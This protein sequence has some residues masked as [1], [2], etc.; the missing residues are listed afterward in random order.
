MI[1]IVDDNSLDETLEKRPSIVEYD[2]ERSDLFEKLSD[3]L[4][5]SI[6][7][8][9]V[10]LR[11]EAGLVACK[12]A[13]EGVHG[14][15]LYADYHGQDYSE[16]PRHISESLKETHQ[17]LVKEGLRDQVTIIASGGITLA[18]HV[19]K[20]IICGADLVGIDTTVLVALQAEFLGETRKRGTYQ[21]RPRKIDLAWG[22]QRLVNL[23]G[24][25]HDQLIEILSA[26]GMR[27]VR[28]LRGDIGRSMMDAELREQSFKGIAWATKN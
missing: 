13:R 12:L 22:A 21:L 3:S 6:V 26:M 14:L 23:F 7:I 4:P 1:P 28:R 10:P 16:D 2:G 5:S 17:L 18:E 27:D 9:R 11:E 8:A 24:V 19:P 20:A 15:H 25:W